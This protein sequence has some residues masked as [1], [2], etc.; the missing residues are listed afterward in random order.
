MVLGD[1]GPLKITDFNFGHELSGL[2]EY[3]DQ[4]Q[5]NILYYKW[6]DSSRINTDTFE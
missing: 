6:R 3:G 4:I 5:Q 2:V 1:D